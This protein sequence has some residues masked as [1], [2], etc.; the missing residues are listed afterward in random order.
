[1][2]HFCQI[3]FLN[4]LLACPDSEPLFVIMER[5]Y[6]LGFFNAS[7]L[8]TEGV[9][10]VGPTFA[11]VAALACGLVISIGNCCSDGLPP[12]LVL[13]SSAM[14]AQYLLNVPLTTAM[15]T[16]G[17]GLLF[18]LWYLTPRTVFDEGIATMG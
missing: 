3:S 16:H 6:G 15:L 1:L 9:A 18:L 2:T 4:K 12:R 10:S 5:T 8:A 13:L 7:L 17:A 14:L 11:P